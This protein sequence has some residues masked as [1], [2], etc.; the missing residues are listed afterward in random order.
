MAQNIAVL[1]Q[2]ER[3]PGPEVRSQCRVDSPIICSLHVIRFSCWK[4]CEVNVT[5]LDALGTEVQLRGQH[6]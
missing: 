5:A 6:R 1:G 2:V 3:G 4:L